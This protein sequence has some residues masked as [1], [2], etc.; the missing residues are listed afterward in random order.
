MARRGCGGFIVMSSMAGQ[1]GSPR[2][3]AYAA[4]KAFGAIL[5]E[6][7]WR[8]MRPHH[9]DVLACVAG[10]VSTPNL[11]AAKSTRAPGTVSPDQ[12]A[13]ASLRGLGR[14]PRVVPGRLMKLS[15]VVTSRL[16][17]RRTAIALIDKASDDLKPDLPSARPAGAPPSEPDRL[18]R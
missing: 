7:L 16:L 11:N 14:G 4:T 9:V 10:A 3:A 6:S 18:E 17:P 15:S 5:A 13:E 1:Q 8:E 2:I 12:V